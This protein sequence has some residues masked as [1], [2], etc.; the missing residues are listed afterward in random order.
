MGGLGKTTLAQLVYNDDRVKNDDNFEFR[1][2]VCVTANYDYKRIL[3]EMIE[4]HTEMKYD[5]NTISLDLLESRFRE[6]LARKRF[7]L[8]LND[9]WIENYEEWEELRTV[10]ILG[11]KGSTVLVTSRNSRVSD[12]MGTR[13]RNVADNVRGSLVDIGREIVGKCKGLPL[14]VKAMAGLL[15]GNHDMNN[16]KRILKHEI[17]E[18]EERSTNTGK[19][20]VLPALKLSYGHLP[21]HLKQCFAYCYIFPK[22]YVFDKMELVKV[23]KAQSF[24][25]SRR[26]D[27]INE[28][29]NDY[30]DELLMSSYCCQVKDNEPCPVSDKSRH[31]SLLCNNA[32]QAAL[33]TKLKEKEGLKK[34]VFEW[35]DRDSGPQ[36]G[37]D[38]EKVLEDLQPHSNLKELQIF[39]YKGTRFPS[40]MGDGI[41]QNLVT[42]SISHCSKC[43]VLSLGEL[44]HLGELYIK[45]M[46]ELEEWPEGQYHS[47]YILKVGSCPK[48]KKLPQIFFNLQVLKIKRCDSLRELPVS[49]SLEFLILVNNLV[50][51]WNEA[52]LHNNPVF[53]NRALPVH[54]GPQ[55][56]EI[57]G[58]K[59][60]STLPI[61]EHY[62][63]LQYLALDGCHAGTLVRAIPD[64]CSLHSLVISNISNLTSLPKWPNLPGL[65]ALYIRN[66]KDLVSLSEEE[67]SFQ[68]LTFLI[69]LSVWNFPK[70]VTLPN[71]GLPASVSCLSIGSCPGLKSLGPR[72]MLKSLTSLRDLYIEDCPTVETFPDEGLPSSFKHLHVEGCLLLT[73]RCQ[74]DIGPDWSNIKDIPDLEFKSIKVSSVQ[75]SLK[76]HP[77]IRASSGTWYQHFTYCKGIDNKEIGQPQ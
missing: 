72:E 49:P 2:W 12:I 37:G 34:V 14:A 47:L 29:G 52:I 65:E 25:Q 53:D 77:K 62:R 43:K 27:I 35:S 66:C 64:S 51:D 7:L 42:I 30:F 32:E 33:A 9:V 54:F 8:V 16:W 17:W 41:L 75:N 46:Q 23:W 44:P 69:M 48:L 1:M 70:L 39:H 19:P 11:E 76:E 50:L 57:S 73:R 74:K 13:K 4:Y 26:R 40:W 15:R 20:I 5:T 58:C 60:L 31:V 56:L 61:P 10:F 22:A 6:F 59:L 28:I 55:K 3:K 71:K 36:D 21:S 18:A 45:R 67:A 68:G 24:I 38:D 63:R